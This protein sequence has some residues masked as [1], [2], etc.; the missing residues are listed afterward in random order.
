MSV[1]WAALSAVLM[2]V[3]GCLADPEPHAPRDAS[4]DA[5]DAADGAAGDA[6]DGGSRGWCGQTGATPTALPRLTFPYRYLN[7]VVT[8][9]NCDQKDDVILLAI[10]DGAGQGIHVTLGPLERILRSRGF[11][12]T[13][14]TRPY[15]AELAEL[16]GDSYPDL[17]VVG[18]ERTMGD[19][20][21]ITNQ[22]VKLLLFEGTATLGFRAAGSVTLPSLAPALEY[23]QNSR[24]FMAL[25]DLDGDAQRDVVVWSG[26]PYVTSNT[27][28]LE[29]SPWGAS[30]VARDVR[31]VPP[32]GSQHGGPIRAWRSRDPGVTKAHDSI[33]IASTSGVLLY[34]ND[35]AG[36]LNP[37]TIA[38][39]ARATA[40][41]QPFFDL[42]RDGQVDIIG[43]DMNVDTGITSIVGFTAMGLWPPVFHR[44]QSSVPVPSP[45]GGAA[46]V[47]ADFEGDGQPELVLLDNYQ[48]VGPYT[49]RVLYDLS[50]GA[51]LT[52][53]TLRSVTFASGWQPDQ[54]LIGDFDGSGRPEVW[55]LDQ[56]GLARGY[57]ILQ[58]PIV[59]LP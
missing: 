13:G 58:D 18:A 21:L 7:G 4:V 6:G 57:D 35:G 44:M 5:A 50:P 11:V 29:L 59:E 23:P 52:A 10:S 26:D 49:L 40:T 14:T 15:A 55:T 45:P 33:F 28:Q 1:R 43:A 39:T 9:L 53:S 48:D 12:S 41:A 17:V 34:D 25:L 22:V 27:V 2:L 37:G 3:A 36:L 56:G 16:S 38:P 46:T 51:E 47:V 24:M 8:D 31:I 20:G 19:A 32:E 30:P 42:D 54:L